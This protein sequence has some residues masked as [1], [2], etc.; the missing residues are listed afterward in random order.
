[1]RI[2]FQT[3]CFL[4]LTI[5]IFFFASESHSQQLDRV[6]EITGEPGGTCSDLHKANFDND[7]W[8]CIAPDYGLW[9]SRDNGESWMLKTEVKYIPEWD[10]NLEVIHE[11]GILPRGETFSWLKVKK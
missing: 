9:V 6:W 3:K 4:V 7:T 10:I 8:F 2:H 11:S 5:T 1:M